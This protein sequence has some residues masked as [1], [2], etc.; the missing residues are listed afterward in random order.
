MAANLLYATQFMN[1]EKSQS[2]AKSAIELPVHFIKSNFFRVVHSGGAWFGGDGHGNLHL[3]FF[4]ERTAIPKSVILSVDEKGNVL[5]ESH[6]DSKQGIVREMEVDVVFTFKDAVAF[7]HALG[8]NIKSVQENQK[9]SNE[10]KVK[11]VKE[12]ILS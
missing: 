11:E 3:T 7:Y 12:T 1:E 8:E 5:A 9:K 4:N 6:R 2:S 10:D